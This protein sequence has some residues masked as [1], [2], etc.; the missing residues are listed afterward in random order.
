MRE[1]DFAGR[2]ASSGNPAI[3]YLYLLLLNNLAQAEVGVFGDHEKSSLL[4]HQL[5]LFA[6]S[7]R[8]N[9]LGE[10]YA[11]EEMAQIDTFLQNA[12][13]FALTSKSVTAPAA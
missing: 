9:A 12:A 5:A 11:R 7:A 3:D 2:F 13:V 8:D 6:V 4:F 10:G 1:T